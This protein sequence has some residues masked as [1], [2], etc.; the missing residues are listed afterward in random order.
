MAAQGFLLIASFLLILFVL[1][2]PLGSGLARLI[3]AVPL[4]GVTGVERILWRTLGITDHEMNW[5]QY[6]LALL[7]LN[8]LGLGILFCLLFWQEWLPLN[9]QRLPGLSWDLAL[10]TAVS[11]VTNTNWQAYSGESTLSYFSQMAGLTVQNFLSAA[12]GIAVVFALIRAFTRQNVH[13]LGN[14]WKDLVR[15]T[16]WILFPIALIIALFFIQQGVPQN[17]SAYQP[18]TTLEGAKQLLPMGPVAS[19]EAIK[20]LGTNGGGFFNANSSHPFENPTAL[21]NMAQM[22]AIFLIPAALCFAFGE[23]TGDRRQGRA[24]LWAMSLIFVVCVAVVMWAEAQGNPHL[25]AAGADSSVN[26]EGKETR[27]GVLASSMFAVVTTAASCGAVDAMHDSFTA[28]GGMVPMWLMQI[29][30]VVFGGV[31]SGLY[32]MLLFVLLAVFIAGLMIGRTPE[33]LGKKIDVREMKMTA[34]AILVTPM[35]VLLGSALAMMTDA[36]RSAMLNPGPHGFSEVLYALSSAAN[37]N[38]SAFAGLSA[39][40]PFWNGLLAFCMFVGRFGVII[41]VMAI[42]G[43]L[44]SKKVQPAS[45]GTLATHGALFIGL[46]IGTVLLVGALTFI[47]ALALGPVAEHFSLP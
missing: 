35:L 38:G 15:I 11:F 45:P 25:L 32:G 4:P 30:E 42:A 21:T 43:S 17:L 16:L 27:F 1:A 12:T 24:L 6:L 20:M 13:T 2:K 5:R 37:N 18:I 26:M 44:V 40:S 23:A 3:A 34:L 9:P 36:G 46:L 28:L 33:Y 14:A 7:T 8:L 10:N 47:P 29:G 31:G 39:N 22:L 19:Q 41:P